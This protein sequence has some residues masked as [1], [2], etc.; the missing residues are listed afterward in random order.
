MLLRERFIVIAY[1]F[2]SLGLLLY[3]FTQIDL[4]L[5]V[6]K[7]GIIQSSQ[8]WFQSIG[9]FDR[10]LSTFLYIVLLIFWFSLY[11]LMV[12]FSHKKK[13]PLHIIWTVIFVIVC[14]SLISYPAFSYDFFNYM[15]TA[16]TVALYHKN[17]YAVIPLDF[18]GF[19]PWILFMRWTHLPSAY[20]P[21][22]IVLTLPVYLLSFGAFLPFVFLLKGL[23]SLSYVLSCVALYAA[24]KKEKL[25]NSELILVAFAFNPLVVIESLISPHNDIIMMALV[26]WAYVFFIEKKRWVS[27]FLFVSSI[28]LKFMTIFL[29]PAYF[30]KWNRKVILSCML[31]GFA[32]VLL[33]REVLPWYFLWLVPF[34]SLLS[35]STEVFVILYGSSLALLLRYAPYLYLGN[36]D[37]PANLWKS[38]VTVLPV[39][40][41]FAVAGALFARRIMRRS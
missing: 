16:K 4:G 29:I 28:G 25:K 7:L 35:Q 40:C 11:A 26:L 1:S 17:P 36:W 21:L 38:L 12:Y 8:R 20:T 39:F 24:S 34:M 10:P 27:F 19:D 32:L 13:L 41:S 15:F 2:A 14:I 18:T 6:S 37:S 5:A 22:W 33:Q 30:L 9:Y 31:L 3:S 23:F